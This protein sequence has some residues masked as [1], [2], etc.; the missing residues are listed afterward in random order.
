MLNKADILGHINKAQL[1]DL[2]VRSGIRNILGIRC[3]EMEPRLHM[4]QYPGLWLKEGR[5]GPVIPKMQEKVAD[6]A[7][8]IYLTNQRIFFSCLTSFS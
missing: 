2:P 5:I 7:A 4:C 8:A 1:M 3:S 6:Q